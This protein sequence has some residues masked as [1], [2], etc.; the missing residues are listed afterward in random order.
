MPTLERLSPRIGAFV[1]DI[2]LRSVSEEE[3]SFIREALNAN[4]VVFFRNQTLDASA[5]YQLGRQFGK[6]TPY[7]YVEGLKEFPEIVEVIKRPEDILNFGGVWHSDTAYLDKP[8]MAGLLYGVEVPEK[9]G[10]TLFTNMYAVYDSLSP[11]MQAYLATLSAV[12]DA[13][14]AA[15]AA[16][17]PADSRKGLTAE[18]PAVR[19]H[20]ETGKSLLYVNRAHTTHFSG[21]T[22][23]ESQELLSFLFERIE[24]PEFSYRFH[25]QP[26]S[27]A[28]WDNR[29]CQ[30]YPIN[31]YHGSQRRMLRISLAGDKPRGPP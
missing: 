31:D 19:V 9:G 18:H 3:I 23:E 6:P 27:L 24:Q 14:N 1:H 28:F 2:D 21:M 13:D 4:L 10:D 8:A 17:R 20:P 5:L 16:T 15:I 7:P 29:A 22:R 30:H 11:G 12:N 25:W 26:G